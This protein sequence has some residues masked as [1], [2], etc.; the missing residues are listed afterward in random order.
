MGVPQQLVTIVGRSIGSG[1]AVHLASKFNI[2]A[3]ILIT[4]ILSIR[5]VTRSLFGDLAA[6]LVKDRFEN[7]DIICKVK[8]P[9]L[10]VH[11]THD[12]IVPLSHSVQLKSRF[13]FK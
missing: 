7:C 9:V 12:S 6:I 4:P 1:P 3:L 5:E 2:G 10:F 8:C 11:G 13:K